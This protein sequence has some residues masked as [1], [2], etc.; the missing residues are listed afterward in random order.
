MRG[1]GKPIWLKKK[2]FLLISP[3]ILTF[4]VFRTGLENTTMFYL[5]WGRRWEGGS[6]LGTRVHPWRIHIDV[7]QN[8]YNIVNNYPPIKINKF[9][10]K[11]N[12]KKGARITVIARSSQLHD[13]F[14]HFSGS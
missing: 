10:L 6:G 11:I 3:S 1:V 4:W 9:I 5:K 8:Q 7:W 13:Q 2:E 14:F 12:K